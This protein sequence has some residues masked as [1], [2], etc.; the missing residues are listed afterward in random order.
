MPHWLSKRFTHTQTETLVF[1]TAS[2]GA[3]RIRVVVRTLSHSTAKLQPQ[4]A[5]VFP[6]VKET[7]WLQ[8]EMRIV[9]LG[10]SWVRKRAHPRLHGSSAP[11]PTVTVLIFKT[12]VEIMKREIPSP[13]H[14][15]NTVHGD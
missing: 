7:H 14:P 2:S 3:Q 15:V 9:Q 4:P 5:C 13:L 1:Q 8:N 12:I 10:P 6:I 11:I